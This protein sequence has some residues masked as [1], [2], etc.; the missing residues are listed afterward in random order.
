MCL[1]VYLAQQVLLFGGKIS[2][3]LF[4]ARPQTRDQESE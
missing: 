3:I 2:I 4:R 1:Y